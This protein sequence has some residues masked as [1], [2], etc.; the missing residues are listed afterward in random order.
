M[1]L[2]LSLSWD[3]CRDGEIPAGEA[4]GTPGHS[5]GMW[6]VKL[7]RVTDD[8]RPFYETAATLTPVMVLTVV[9]GA[10]KM[11]GR[12]PRRWRILYATVT[13]GPAF[14]V[15]ASAFAGL[16]TGSSALVWVV[17]VPLLLLTGLGLGAF[18]TALLWPEH[19][20]ID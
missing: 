4:A 5:R 19:N 16:L 11:A 8:L 7:R 14:L 20:P 18:V 13:V 3:K 15:E 6:Q 1:M 2:A 12:W 9:L 17:F 10:R